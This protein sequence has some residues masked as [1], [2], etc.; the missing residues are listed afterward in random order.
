MRG[1]ANLAAAAAARGLAAQTFGP[2]T[3]LTPPTYLGREPLLTGAAFG[4]RAGERS[5]LI[6]GEG[7]HFLVETVFRKPADSTA[8]LAQRDT[9]RDA[10][11]QAARQ[12]RVQAYLQ[13]LREKAK[14]VDRRKELYRTPAQAAEQPAGT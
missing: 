12:G 14:V 8:W 11:L 6:A 13:A 3:R 4:L 7:G 2:F 1:V 9:Q 5:G 10:I